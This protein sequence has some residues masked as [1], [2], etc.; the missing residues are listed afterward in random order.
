[1]SFVSWV[2]LAAGDEKET[3]SAALGRALGKIGWTDDG[4]KFRWAKNGATALAPAVLVQGVAA[5]SS[6]DAALDV[7]GGTSTGV[8][9][10]TV[11][12]QAAVT[13]DQYKDGWITIDTGP[14]VGMY[15]VKSH[16]AASSGEDLTFTLADNDP[17][18]VA[19]SSGTTK[20][21]LRPSPFSGTV[22][23]PTTVTGP[24]LGIT[25]CSVTASHYYWVQEADFGLWDTDVAPV[26]N[27]DLI[28]GA[29]SAGKGN[30]RSSAL[31]DIPEISIAHSVD[32]GAGADKPNFVRINIG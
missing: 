6:Q 31:D 16:G 5:N 14:G 11:T 22:V 9:Q 29:S 4:R 30:A 19:L 27:T 17:L 13:R 23:A 7:V 32:A 2:G 10:I 25:A 12:V 15:R 28:F 24:L 1:M 3:S 21:G 18:R 26:V 20:V 8:N